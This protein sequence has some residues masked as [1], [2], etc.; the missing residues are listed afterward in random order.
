MRPSAY[1][2]RW[3]C[4]HALHPYFCL[5]MR[6]LLTKVELPVLDAPTTNIDRFITVTD[7][8]TGEDVSIYKESVHYG[9]HIRR[10]SFSAVL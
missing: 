5:A 1:V 8:A 2:V 9:G 10:R 4:H 7:D 3:P 6:S